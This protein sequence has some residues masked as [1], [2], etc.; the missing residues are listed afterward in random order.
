MI[1]EIASREKTHEN[2]L[3]KIGKDAA[4]SFLKAWGEITG[5]ARA[6]I[7]TLDENLPAQDLAR[8]HKQ[9]SNCVMSKGGEVTARNNTIELGRIYLNL[10]N[11]GKI[12]FLTLLLE[13]FDISQ[14]ELKDKLADFQEELNYENQ[15]ELI[16]IM[17]PPRNKIFRQFLALSNGLKFIVDMRSDV[18]KFVK[19]YPD[20]FK[21]ERDLHNLLSSW[22]DVGLLDMQPITWNSP[23]SL[24]E[25]LIKYEAVHEIGSWND[26]KNRLDSDMRC[27]AFFH[28]KMPEE[29]LIFVEVALNNKIATGIQDLLDE[30][31]PT[32]KQKDINTAVF[33]SISNAQHGLSGINL[34]NFLIKKVVEKLSGEFTDIKNFVT[35]SP[36]PGFTKWL[37]ANLA[38]LDL[39]DEEKKSITEILQNQSKE[40]RENMKQKITELCSYYLTKVKK[41]NK[42]FDPV[43][44]FHLSNGAG[45]KQINWNSNNSNK[46]IKQ[47]LGMMIN[48]HYEL[49]KIDD[50]HENYISTGIISCSRKIQSMAKNIKLQEA[51]NKLKN[52]T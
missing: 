18:L 28:Y 45:M 34:G 32:T 44:N 14:D 41:G 12:K 51:T 24:L 21:L 39:I 37:K 1:S 2:K 49:N 10:S 30:S 13:K 23:A 7:G 17:I 15:Q 27:F 3:A 33:Y 48:Y 47:S 9:M 35:L 16:E 42:A 46:G 31:A 4:N 22:F 20:F 5:A 25:K 43:A 38:H 50:N 40:H 6:L 36:I 52:N 11:K 19:D 8:L 29:P 26:L